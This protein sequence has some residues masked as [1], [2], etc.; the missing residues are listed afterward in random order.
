LAFREDEQRAS[1]DS[2]STH[3]SQNRG[4]LATGA[5]A[6]DI[7][8]NSGSRGRARLHGVSS[9]PTRDPN[10]FRRRTKTR[11]DHANVWIKF[12]YFA[13]CGF[14][15]AILEG[16]TQVFSRFRLVVRCRGCCPQRCATSEATASSFNE[17]TLK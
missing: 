6:G 10:R 5:G 9:L 12:A 15:Q 13:F 7:E 17:T 4:E 11:A 14:P 3:A 1:F 2:L 16:K 8:L